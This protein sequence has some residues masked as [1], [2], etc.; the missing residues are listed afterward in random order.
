MTSI[1]RVRCHWT[2]F[3]GAPGYS[4]FYSSSVPTAATLTAIRQFFSGL[5]VGIPT[6]VSIQ[7]EG[8]GDELDVSSYQ[9]I[10]Q[11]SA[12]QPAVVVGGA[13]DPYAGPAG[14]VCT[15][16]TSTVI[17]GRR[18][19]GKTF[20]VPA[21]GIFQTDGSILNTY[22][23]TAQAAAS[24]LVASADYDQV[25][26]HK[27]GGDFGGSLAPVVSAHVPDM[28]AVLRSRRG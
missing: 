19:L 15:W 10:G 12:T 3:P 20:I 13:G 26:W 24:D 18:V 27:S 21:A 8:Q 5:T 23:A 14:F 1:W 2:G 16:R 6:D 28:A 11:W 4:N 22:L 7:V 25:I 17:N 9:I